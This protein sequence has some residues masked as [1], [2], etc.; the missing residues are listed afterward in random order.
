MNLQDEYNKHIQNHKSETQSLQVLL[1]CSVCDEK[2][3]D[4]A[5]YKE[6]TLFHTEVKKLLKIKKTPKKRKAAKR[7]ASHL[8]DVCK[9]SFTK[10]CLLVR[11]KRIHTGE[12]PYVVS[13]S[14]FI[15]LGKC[16]YFKVEKWY[17]IDNIFIFS[18]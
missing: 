12:K 9:K 1:I 5:K 10:Y 16:R 18:F 6:H 7:T 17:Q 4:R 15:Q 8:C 11:H 2:F 3:E 14:H 13:N